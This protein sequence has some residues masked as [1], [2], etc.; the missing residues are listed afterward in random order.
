MGPGADG[1]DDAER[2]QGRD[3]GRVG[4]G[5]QGLPPGM[6]G[7]ENLAWKDLKFFGFEFPNSRRIWTVAML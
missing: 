5:Y 4:E 2:S 7:A 3:I 1:G 6:T